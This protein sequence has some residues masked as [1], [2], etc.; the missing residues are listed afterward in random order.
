M[1]KNCLPK[2]F[3]H[4]TSARVGNAAHDGVQLGERGPL[5][6]I[7]KYFFMHLISYIPYVP[8]TTWTAI[9]A[10]CSVVSA[11]VVGGEI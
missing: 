10:V 9:T 11:A 7:E 4:K 3:P 8:A 6:V 2:V 1:P 5:L